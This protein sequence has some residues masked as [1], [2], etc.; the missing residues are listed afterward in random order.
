MILQIWTTW[1]S[2]CMVLEIWTARQ[3]FFPILRH[4]L[5]PFAPLTTQ[6]IKNFEKMRKTA[7]EDYNFTQVYHKWQ[8]YDYGS[9]DMKDDKKNYFVILDHFLP[10]YPPK[11]LKSKSFKKLKKKNTELIIILQKCSISHYHM[12]YSSWDM[13]CDRSNFYF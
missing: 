10:F 1:Q 9:W 4:F 6:K 7:Q 2:W 11:N 5:R 12:L 8:W 13:V 3:N